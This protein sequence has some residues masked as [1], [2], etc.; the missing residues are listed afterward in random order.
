MAEK[1]EKVYLT[2]TYIVGGVIELIDENGCI[3]YYRQRGLEHISE[4]QKLLLI[5]MGMLNRYWANYPELPGHVSIYYEDEEI[6]GNAKAAYPSEIIEAT[7][8]TPQL[9]KKYLRS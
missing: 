8:L 1:K 4:E 3:A 5:S 9:V 2:A 6:L 7:K